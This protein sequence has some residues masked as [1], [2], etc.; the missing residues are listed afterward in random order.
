MQTFSLL[1]G[2]PQL[3]S[4][5]AITLAVAAT[6]IAADAPPA[7][8]A[9]APATAPVSS[10]PDNGAI[11]ATVGGQPVFL[12]QVDQ[13]A[14]A[15]EH[16]QDLSG[17]TGARVKAAVLL[18]LIDRQMV[19]NYLV[20]ANFGA[21]PDEVDAEI[22]HLKTEL[23]HAKRTM[24]EYLSRTH[25]TDAMLRSELAWK[26]T[27][28][29]YLKTQISDESLEAYFKSHHRDFDGTELRVSHILLR[30]ALADDD[31]AVASLIKQAEQI[32][33][34]IESGQVTFEAAAE[35]YSVGP[36]RH[37]GGDLGFIP[38]HGLMLEPF[39]KA[40]FALEKNEISQPVVTYFGIHLIRVTDIK[41][42]DKQWT[43]VRGPLKTALTEH[44]FDQLLARQRGAVPVQ[45]TGKCPYFKP[46]TTEL[47]LPK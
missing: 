44:L 1:R 38:R 4:A 36:S 18:Q 17:D 42:G 32:R 27:W 21:T 15:A 43:D 3:L 7:P 14:A 16:G 28:E 13:M 6:A 35:K 12:R 46:G 11:A 41:P 37:K 29:K 26:L 23:E 31:S 34:Q 2:A 8:A 10:A 25:Q 20:K 45:Y 22:A 5:A 39:A 40:A 30:P 24:A 33:Q 9:A 19:E 47:V